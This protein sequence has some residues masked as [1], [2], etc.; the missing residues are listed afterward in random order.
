MSLD[1]KIKNR[2]KISDKKEYLMEADLNGKEGE[3]NYWWAGFE[4][5]NIPACLYFQ[6]QMMQYPIVY[7]YPLENCYPV[8]KEWTID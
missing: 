8:K 2:D 7:V 4:E 6:Q 1:Y 5:Y 3:P